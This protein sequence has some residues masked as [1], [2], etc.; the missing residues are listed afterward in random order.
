MEQKNQINLNKMGEVYEQLF[1]LLG[2][3]DVTTDRQKNNGTQMFEIPFDH[4]N[5]PGLKLRFA[6]YSSGYVRNVNGAWTSYQLNKKE[7]YKT[8]VYEWGKYHT[9]KRVLIYSRENRLKFLFEFILKNYYL[10]RH[11][12]V[13]YRDNYIPNPKPSVSVTIDG[14]R[15]NIQ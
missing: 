12:I 5:V 7:I 13:E 14:H 3:K 11:K 2:V 9:Y 6:I 4:D 10:K 8:H 1:K 15:Y